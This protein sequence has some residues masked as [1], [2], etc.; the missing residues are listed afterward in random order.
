[1]CLCTNHSQCSSHP[2]FLDTSFLLALV[3]FICIDLYVLSTLS[4]FKN[5][6]HK[7]TFFF[8]FNILQSKHSNK[9]CEMLVMLGG[10]RIE[11]NFE[12]FDLRN[13]IGREVIMMS[14][15]SPAMS[16]LSWTN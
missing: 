14:L 11:E 10:Y 8:P 13:L 12:G 4:V 6:F 1:M 5:G 15:S 7:L 2:D 9:H 16:S 3:C